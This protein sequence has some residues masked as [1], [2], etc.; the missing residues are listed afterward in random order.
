MTL[1]V[2]VAVP[3]DAIGALN[4]G[5]TGTIQDSG[6]IPFIQRNPPLSVAVRGVCC[7]PVSGA[8]AAIS[9]LNREKTGNFREFGRYAGI[10]SRISSSNQ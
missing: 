6:Q 5:H 1:G 3:E 10:F 7:E 9:L 8:G 2:E 4:H